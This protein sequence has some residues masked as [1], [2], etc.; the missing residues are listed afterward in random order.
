MILARMRRPCRMVF[1]CSAVS[2]G[3][4]GALLLVEFNASFSN[5]P[6][7]ITDASVNLYCSLEIGGG[8][9]IRC[10]QGFQSS[11]M[12]GHFTPWLGLFGHSSIS[13]RCVI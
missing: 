9:L 2:T 6:L 5:L 4:G 8:P 10:K 1:R 13:R 11:V 7:P 3:E 12:E